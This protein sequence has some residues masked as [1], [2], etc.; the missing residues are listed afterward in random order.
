MQHAYAAHF[1]AGRTGRGINSTHCGQPVARLALNFLDRFRTVDGEWKM[2]KDEVV[3]SAGDWIQQLQLAH[4]FFPRA[5][6][7]LQAK[8]LIGR[9]L[10]LCRWC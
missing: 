5:N 9:M 8:W 10:E 2:G 6:D 3:R 7:R 4:L 1:P